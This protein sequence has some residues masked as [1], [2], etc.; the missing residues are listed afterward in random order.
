MNKNIFIW[1]LLAAVSVSFVSAVEFQINFTDSNTYSTMTYAN[2]QIDQLR[3]EPYPVNPGEYF[4]MWIKVQNVGSE[5]TNNATFVL[6]P[7]YPFS[8]DSNEDAFRQY[9]ELNSE[10]VVLKYKI[11][12]DKDAVKGTNQIDLKYN[13]GENNNTWLVKTFDIEVE[14]AQTD[15]DLVVQEMSQ[16]DI[17]I[18]VANTGKNPANSV[19]VRI[20][21]QDSFQAEGTSG[22]MV[23]NLENGDY[24]LVGFT[25]QSKGRNSANKLQVQIDYTDSIGE[26]RSVTKEVA[27]EIGQTAMSAANGQQSNSSSRF[28]AS[29]STAVY[30]TWWFWLIII[31][32]V[33][34]VWKVIKIYAEKKRHKK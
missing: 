6:V 23:G 30:Q 19:I 10:P 34:A 20:P 24:T 14:D 12:V 2:L 26:R 8:I 4:T 13:E 25:V 21:E 17:T 28:R 31:I 16:N 1:I 7:E 11:R 9:G 18:A 27:L 15:F 5:L 3:Y 33:F 29:S 22:Q 32:V